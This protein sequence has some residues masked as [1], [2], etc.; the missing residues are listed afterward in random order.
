MSK[1]AL[2]LHEWTLSNS[3]CLQ[4][5]CVTQ[6]RLSSS[7]PEE[8]SMKLAT[9]LFQATPQ[10]LSNT[11]WDCVCLEVCRHQATGLCSVCI[12]PI[13]DDPKSS[14]VYAQN[15]TGYEFKYELYLSLAFTCH[16]CLNKSSIKSLM[17]MCS[18]FF[19]F[20]PSQHMGNLVP[21]N[22]YYKN[23]RQNI[24][25]TGHF[26]G[27]YTHKKKNTI[28]C[29][30]QKRILRNNFIFCANVSVVLGEANVCRTRMFCPMVLPAFH[31]GG[32]YRVISEGDSFLR[33]FVSRNGGYSTKIKRSNIIE[34][35][36]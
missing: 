1:V 5:Q 10:R 15:T 9:Q 11:S 26:R 14:T 31:H 20:L 21:H 18:F 24:F 33:T 28:Y 23:R 36:V 4:S 25:T 27:M 6:Q 12:I 30:G 13:I 8:C 7:V 2:K 22:N 32:V 16:T 34:L 19:F 35:R 3:Y 29:S 17:R